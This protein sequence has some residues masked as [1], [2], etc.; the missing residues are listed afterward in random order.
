MAFSV[1]FALRGANFVLETEICEDEG[2]LIIKYK[3]LPF[4]GHLSAFIKR[5]MRKT[6]EKNPQIMNGNM[7][8]VHRSRKLHQK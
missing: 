6:S 2:S 1:I 4:R 3:C 5:Q 7:Y 8:S